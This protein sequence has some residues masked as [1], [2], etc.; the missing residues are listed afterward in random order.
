MS[1]NGT[2]IEPEETEVATCKVSGVFPEPETVSFLV[3]GE[4]IEVAE[5]I[6]VEENDDGTFEASATLALFPDGSYNGDEVTCF[7]LARQGAETQHSEANDT[8][9]LEVTCKL[10]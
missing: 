9:T 3:G 10:N 6:I 2:I 5:D 1:D 8:F 4:T 7:S